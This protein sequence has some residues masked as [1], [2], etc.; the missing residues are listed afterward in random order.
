MDDNVFQDL[1]PTDDSARNDNVFGDLVPKN[2]EGFDDLV[3]PAQGLDKD[4]PLQTVPGADWA[5]SILHGMNKANPFILAPKAGAW[6]ANKALTATGVQPVDN[7]QV[8]KDIDNVF[9]PNPVADNAD[10]ALSS[11]GDMMMTAPEIGAGLTMTGVAGRLPGVAS[12]LNRDILARMSQGAKNVGTGA[13]REMAADP[14]S[15]ARYLIQN[16]GAGAGVETAHDMAKDSPAYVRIPA[17]IAGGIAGGAGS[18]AVPDLAK[19]A[20]S[21]YYKHISPPM[22]AARL[23][24]DKIANVLPNGKVADWFQGMYDARQSQSYDKALPAAAQSIKDMGAG[25]QLDEAVRLRQ[26][27]PGFNPTLAES[28]GLPSQVANQKM[29]ES[30]ASGNVLD[31]FVKRKQGSEGAIAKYAE[32]QAPTIG[33][34]VFHG[35]R[36]V[37][38][39]GLTYFT[40]NKDMAESYVD[41]T[42][43]RFGTGSGS[44]SQH[45]ISISKPAPE[46]VVMSEAKKLGIDN[47]NYTPASVFDTELHGDA[48]TQLASNLRKQGYDGAILDDVA[49]GKNITDKAHI[50]FSPQQIN[51]TVDFKG[52]MQRRLQGVNDSLET[53]K[54]LNQMDKDN[55]AGQLP[56]ANAYDNGSY[57]R[58][59]LQSLRTDKQAEMSKLSEDMGLED[60]Q[61]L[62][63]SRDGIQSA[64]TSALPSRFAASASPT[65]KK[66]LSLP[67]GEVLSFKDAKYF[68]E[69][70]GQDARQAA[71]MGNMQ[72]AKVIG[73]ARGKMDDYLTNDWAPALGIGQKYQD[74]RGRYLNEYV[75]R[76]DKGATQDVRALGGDNRYRTDNEDVAGTYFR[77]GDVT[78]AKDFH[79]TFAGDP[80]AEEALHGYALDDLRQKA[81]KDGVIDPKALEKW[82]T[83]NKDNLAQFPSLQAK[84]QN[85]QQTASSLAQRQAQLAQRQIDLGNSQLAKTLGD[86]NATVDTLLSD[87]KLLKR[88]VGTMNDDEKQALAR[89][90][91]QKATQGGN[92]NPAAMKDFLTKNGDA[93]KTVLAPG[94]IDALNDIQKA[95][96]MNA[97]TAAPTGKGEIP[98]LDAFKDKLGSTPQQMMSR[99]FALK[100][101]RIGPEY[102]I[103]DLLTRLGLG[104]NQRQQTAI[105]QK[106][107]YDPDFAKELAGFVKQTT[108]DPV[109]A[110]RMKAYMFNSGISALRDKDDGQGEGNDVPHVTVTRGQGS[111]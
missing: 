42:N 63:V 52:A 90:M 23:A 43:D 26:T 32:D 100:S 92:T 72:D 82:T 94:H 60:A 101:G 53:Q 34:K 76:F 65:I 68:M 64:V 70:L 48:V 77:P 102:A 58:D 9:T 17:E 81:V 98:V 25:P 99:L 14:N 44:L 21:M 69:Q 4:R 47:S 15:A 67:Q 80:Q 71:K 61:H 39:N 59:R 12:S 104:V 31:N 56:Q 1:V 40:P 36:G 87:P 54:T 93:L 95:W 84:V 29:M 73:D 10:K 8:Y 111:N 88:T 13:V 109:K 85:I 16:A 18:T 41:M 50:P 7:T 55:L 96:E 89:T 49:Y 107:M 3:P 19:G 37:N 57:M 86:T 97:N 6:I 30:N 27:I 45:Q 110:S 33:T 103:G 83:A 38:P 46:N 5:G 24:G 106:A 75:N 51:P 2:K 22:W 11:A 35:G 74:W 20:V 28:T 91:W 79:T 108:P 105:M 78:A 62:R 66:I